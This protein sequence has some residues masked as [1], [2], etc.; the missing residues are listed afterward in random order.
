MD[1]QCLLHFVIPSC[2]EVHIPL[3]CSFSLLDR[4]TYVGFLEI[5][6]RQACTADQK[7]HFRIASKMPS[8]PFHTRL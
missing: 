5:L 1:I 7:D 6:V 2:T 4:L 3:F 8:L